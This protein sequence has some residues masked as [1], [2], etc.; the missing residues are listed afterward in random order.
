MGSVPLL[1]KVLER[2]AHEE[3]HLPKGAV[4]H[5]LS[6]GFDR[7][8]GELRGQV[9]DYRAELPDGRGLH[10]RDMVSHWAAHWDH[11]FPT[12]ERW[13]DHLKEDSPGWYAFLIA[14]IVVAAAT[15]IALFIVW[16]FR[17]FDG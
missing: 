2:P 10:I 5:P 6:V 8:V 4:P 3:V 14:S 12:L 7:S 1:D 17:A 16:L 11:V 9:A 13:V 15:A